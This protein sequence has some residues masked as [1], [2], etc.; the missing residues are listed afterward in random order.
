MSKLAYCVLWNLLLIE[1]ILTITTPTQGYIL[2]FK[3]QTLQIMG[4]TFVSFNVKNTA[5]WTVGI[6]IGTDH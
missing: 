1:Q 4:L 5:H 6:L 3:E 2:V